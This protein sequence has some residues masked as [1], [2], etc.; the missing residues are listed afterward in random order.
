[1]RRRSVFFLLVSI[2]ICL[3][4]YGCGNNTNTDVTVIHITQDNLQQL[5]QINNSDSVVW[6]DDTLAHSKGVQSKLR[7]LYDNGTRLIFIRGTMDINDVARYLNLEYGHV[8]IHHPPYN[9]VGVVC[10]QTNGNPIL[11][12]AYAESPDFNES[13]LM[14]ASKFDYSK[15]IP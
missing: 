2:V 13:V 7:Q 11:V 15:D 5:F 8:N 10:Y 9:Y 12:D 14:Y 4:S 6:I 3:S 1:M